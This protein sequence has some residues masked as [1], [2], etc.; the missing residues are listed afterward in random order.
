MKRDYDVIIIGAGVS[1]TAL[2]YTLAKYTDIKNVALF[3]K[4]DDV[5]QVASHHTQNSQ[6]L[7]YGDIETNYS[8][9]KAKS[10]S[11]GARYVEH[12]LEEFATT[13]DIFEKSHKMVLA[14]GEDECQELRERFKK[15]QE[16]FPKAKLLE[17]EEIKEY[18][19]NVVLGR[20]ED[21]EIVALWSPNGYIM[22]Y[23]ALATDF[24]KQA[25]Q[26]AKKKS[27]DSYLST[28][29][30]TITKHHEGYAVHTSD[31]NTYTCD[32]LVVDAGA[33]S[34][35][36]AKQL[37]Y[38]K[39]L[40]IFSV[41]GNF[42]RANKKVLNGKVYR[43]QLDK[44]PFAA[45]HG[46]PDVHHPE[47]TRFGPSAKPL[48][49]LERWNYGTVWDYLKSFKWTWDGLATVFK[50]GTDPVYFNYMMRNIAYDIPYY[51]SRLFAKNAIQIVPTLKK[52]DI[53]KDKGYGG[54]RPQII[55]TQTRSIDMGEARI[56][57][58]NAIFNITP[59]PG[60]STCLANAK[61]DTE[62]LIKNFNGRF[63]FN[64]KKFTKDLA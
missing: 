4:H 52:S 24:H 9:Q 36:L 59:S 31:G 50:I 23:H 11:Q 63:S 48:L 27:F 43:M 12:Y 42:Y 33:M 60:A 40:S 35:K 18:E 55:N 20:D 58:K 16:L 30:K 28:E 15:F 53:T 32:Q 17:R 14:I 45:A 2:Q 26:H 37:G 25:K 7:H 13:K 47:V 56:E 8:Y 34:I 39:H 38:G 49:M 3:E 62:I 22:D 54:A 29:I 41:A 61:R 44:L 64:S 6:T 1:G 51:G 21:E 5:A 57:G 10:V 19:P 46:D